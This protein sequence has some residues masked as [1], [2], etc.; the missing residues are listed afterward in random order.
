MMQVGEKREIYIHPALAYGV[1]TH[2]EKGIYL[3]VVVELF[4]AFETEGQEKLPALIPMDLAFVRLA[5]FQE[6][7]TS[8]Y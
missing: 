2:L 1:H 6:E 5:E 3:R 4:E 7:C 8:I